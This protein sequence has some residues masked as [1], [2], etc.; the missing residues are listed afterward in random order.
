MVSREPTAVPRAPSRACKSPPISPPGMTEIELPPR[1]IESVRCPPFLGSGAA[2]R[3]E[4]EREVTSPAPPGRTRVTS[5]SLVVMGEA[6]V[7]SASRSTS[8]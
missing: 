5:P 1:E 3:G 4:A 6:P 7:S 2:E 8:F